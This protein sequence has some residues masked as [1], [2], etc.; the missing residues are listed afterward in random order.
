MILAWHW[1][2]KIYLHTGHNGICY[3]TV[4][5]V[6]LGVYAWGGLCACT[7]CVGNVWVSS[8]NNGKVLLRTTCYIWGTTKWLPLI[9]NIGND[10]YTECNDH[11]LTAP[12]LPSNQSIRLSQNIHVYSAV[13]RNGKFEE[14]MVRMNGLMTNRLKWHWKHKCISVCACVCV[15]AHMSV[16][17]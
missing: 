4:D 1:P 16:C 10:S 7:F 5:K 13:L 6:N 3:H 8:V 17:V 14:K 2:W 11:S 15:C 9:Q 12:I